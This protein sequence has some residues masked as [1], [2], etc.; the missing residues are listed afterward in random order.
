MTFDTFDLNL[1]RAMEALLQER[2]VTAAARRL[3]VTQSAMSGM[4]KRLRLGLGDELLVMRGRSMV[5]TPRAEQLL[6]PLREV[7]AAVRTRIFSPPAFVPAESD[8]HYVLEATDYTL[9][10]LMAKVLR[11]LSIEAPRV[12]FELVGPGG[13]GASLAQFGGELD[14]LVIP[15]TLAR[16]GHPQAR[17]FDD[18]SVVVAW[19][20]ARGAGEQMS[21][22]DFLAAPH[23]GV[24]VNRS[25]LPPV[26]GW[27]KSA[28]DDRRHIAVYASAYVEVPELVVGTPRIAV[29]HE[30]LARYFA[31]QYE[32][33]I[34]ECPAP[35]PTITNVLQWPHGIEHDPG[36]L[37]LRDKILAAAAQMPPSES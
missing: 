14:L 35:I 2:S 33:R 16:P 17:L 1:L 20:G 13:A 10:I 4:L 8:R 27:L 3:N 5:L 7:L 15:S 30:R 31:R 9:R 28:Y 26:E 21:E 36:L 37:W 32:L 11:E 34:L 12:T 29:M 19:A 24:R 6:G 23:V 18:R 25:R 22:A